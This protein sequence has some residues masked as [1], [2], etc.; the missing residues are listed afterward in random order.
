MCRIY[1]SSKEQ[2][3][4]NSNPFSDLWKLGNTLIYLDLDMVV[5]AFTGPVENEFIGFIPACMT[6]EY[7]NTSNEIQTKVFYEQHLPALKFSNNV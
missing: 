5:T 6:V 3:E 2:S 1:D 7:L 4:N